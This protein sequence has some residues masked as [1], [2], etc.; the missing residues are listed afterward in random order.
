MDLVKV[1]PQRS[2]GRTKAMSHIK[3]DFTNCNLNL[4][5]TNYVL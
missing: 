5:F 1:F 3:L 4:Q 2:F